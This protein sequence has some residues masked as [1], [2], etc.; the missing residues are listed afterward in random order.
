MANNNIKVYAEQEGIV[1]SKEYR[2][3]KEE[4]KD[5]NGKLWPASPEKFIVKVVSCTARLF[6]KEMGMNKPMMLDYEIDKDTFQKIDFVQ[7]F[8]KAKVGFEV[9]TYGNDVLCKP[10]YFALINNK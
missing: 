7:G 2:E 6:S 10:D 4:R 1:I 5:M 9:Q 8:P 3:A